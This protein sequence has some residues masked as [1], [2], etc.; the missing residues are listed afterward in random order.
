MAAI[1]SRPQCVNSVAYSGVVHQNQDKQR[2]TNQLWHIFYDFS[3]EIWAQDIESA[4]HFGS[5]FKT[6]NV[7]YGNE[8]Y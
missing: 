4:L 3:V 7:D 5:Q 2:H 1:M 8:W 6:W